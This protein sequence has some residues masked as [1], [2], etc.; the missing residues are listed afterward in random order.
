MDRQ[1]IQVTSVQIVV[2]R[3]GNM[4]KA[5]L[6]IAGIILIIFVL[7]NVFCFTAP[8]FRNVVFWT[9]YVF[10]DIAI[11][12]QI[13]FLM[14]VILNKN[15]KNFFFWTFPT[16]RIGVIY[17]IVQLIV[18]SSE[19]AFS[20]RLPMWAVVLVNVVIVGVTMVMSIISDMVMG[21]VVCLDDK[22]KEKIENMRKLKI[23]SASVLVHCDD[24]LLKDRLY[25]LDE[26]IRYSDPV[27]TAATEKFENEL[28]EVISRIKEAIKENDYDLA[29]ELCN[30]AMYELEDRNNMC[31]MKK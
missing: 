17:L 3:E 20:A 13:F 30:K 8:F 16:M 12:M 4:K 9:G 5:E 23:L 31:I 14:Y 27:S 24:I 7:F 10:G 11:V 19:M 15:D 1:G 6:K 18:S 29:G 22:V 2:G 26:M 28:L 25:K 21:K